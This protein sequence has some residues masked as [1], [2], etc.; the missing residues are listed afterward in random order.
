MYELLD[1]AASGRELQHFA[2][3]TCAMTHTEAGAPANFSPFE[4]HDYPVS[5]NL[6]GA[7]VLVPLALLRDHPER[8]DR[9]R[10]AEAMA[11][12]EQAH[13]NLLSGRF[14]GS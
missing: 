6:R 12:I 9:P 4:P 8:R 10:M 14:V 13:E 2:A 5:G 1:Q 7:G 11:V 3:L